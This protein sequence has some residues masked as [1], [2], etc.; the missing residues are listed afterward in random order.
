VEK[1]PSGL[2]CASDR[3]E[4]HSKKTHTITA[5]FHSMQQ[6]ESIG[7]FENN[8]DSW[9]HTFAHSRAVVNDKGSDFFITI[10]HDCGFR[11][12]WGKESERARKKKKRRSGFFVGGW[13]ADEED[14]CCRCAPWCR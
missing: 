1:G 4:T 5:S 9:K 14:R 3:K 13:C 12:V 7:P 2:V 8:G 10:S 6:M 11:F